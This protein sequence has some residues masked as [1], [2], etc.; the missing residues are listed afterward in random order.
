MSNQVNKEING[1][2]RNLRNGLRLLLF[3]RIKLREVYAAQ[4]Q[5]VLLGVF[6]AAI[7]FSGS[8]F[9]SLPNPEFSIHGIATVVVQLFF[10]ALCAYLFSKTRNNEEQTLSIYI[11]LLSLWPLF[12]IGWLAI[13]QSP[14]LNYWL[15]QGESKYTYIIYNI[16]MA[17][18]V[19]SAMLRNIGVTLKYGVLILVIYLVTLVVPL[20]YLMFGDFWYAAHTYNAENEKYKSI[21][22]EITYYK[23]FEFLEDMK[24][25]L[26][27]QRNG[28]TDIYFVGFG[29][30][31]T[32]DVFMKDVLYAKQVLDEKYDTNGRSV[33]LINNTKTL[34]NTLLASKSNLTFVLNHI[35]TLVNPDEDLLFLYLTSHGSKDHQLSVQMLP[36]KLNSIEPVELDIALKRSGIKYRVLLVSACY[37]G[38]FIEQL[39]DDYTIVFTASAKNRRSFG[40]SNLSEQT[41]FGRAVFKEQMVRNYNFIEAF[42][43][44]IKSISRRERTEELENSEPQLFVGDKIR[45]KIVNI[46]KDMEKYNETGNA[47]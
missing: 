8:Y 19:V 22:E 43:M 5:I 26:L 34:E 7:L 25:H 41:Y 1:L 31:G 10:I 40:C 16:W 47:H 30:Y 29:S 20:N 2:H 36:L 14:F 3:K 28:I 13:N 11:M 18:I 44:A 17:T 4:D 37:S 38:G 32:Q 27:P 46:A 33:A 9:R 24:A 12:H 21:N 45:E 6:L 23:Q 42:S 39:K 35:G 15:Y